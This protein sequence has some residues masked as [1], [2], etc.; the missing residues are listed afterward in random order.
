MRDIIINLQN[1]DEWKIQ[2]IISINFISSK[3]G[4]E[5]RVMHSIVAIENLH[6]IVTQIMLLMKFLSQFVQNIK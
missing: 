6:L 1:S 2:L 5:E 3:D 4:E